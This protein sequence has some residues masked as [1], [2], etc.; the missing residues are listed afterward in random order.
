MSQTLSP[1]QKE[2]VTVIMILIFILYVVMVIILP[3]IIIWALNAVFPALRI[4]RNFTT[5]LAV[6][7]LFILFHPKTSAMIV[8]SAPKSD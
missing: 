4:P 6:L 5:W 1:K 8:Y 2:E 7:I 3:L